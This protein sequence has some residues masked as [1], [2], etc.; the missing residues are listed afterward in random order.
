MLKKIFLC[1]LALFFIGLTPLT[2]KEAKAVRTSLRSWERVV[3]RGFNNANNKTIYMIVSFKGYIYAGTSNETD[4]GMLYRSKDGINWSRV[5][6]SDF[7]DSGDVLLFP[8]LA[9]EEYLYVG[10]ENDTNGGGVWRSSDGENF[11]QINVDGFGNA[12]NKSIMGGTSYNNQIYVGTDNGTDGAQVWRYNGSG[13]DWTQ[14]NTDGFGAGASNSSVLGME[15]IDSYLYAGTFRAA[16]GQ[17]FR[18]NG[19]SWSQVGGDGLGDSNNQGIYMY[20]GEKFRGYIYVG[21]YNA[22]G[23]S[24]YRSAD[25]TSW[26]EFDETGFGDTSAGILIPRTL[27]SDKIYF[28]SAS[29]SGC[30]VYQ[31]GSPVERIS[32]RGLGDGNNIFTSGGII[33]NN[34]LYV[35]TDNEYGGQIWRTFVGNLP[36]TGAEI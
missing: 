6:A 11:I 35:S 27:S 26:S 7:N 5:A 30:F 12:N 33:F 14:V 1:V 9:T 21:T 24:I 31:Y 18:Y 32:E 36:Q 10:T 19:S 3:N 13:T 20:L 28:G 17:L 2:S 25:G 15:A 29:N 8:F 22:S 4:G 16:G 23:A 34:Y